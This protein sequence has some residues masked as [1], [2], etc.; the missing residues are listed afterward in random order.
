[1]L[2]ETPDIKDSILHEFAKNLECDYI[3]GIRN[4]PYALSEKLQCHNNVKKYKLGEP[5]LG[6]Y[7]LKFDNFY[8]AILHSVV[9]K[10]SQYLDITP[11]DD[12][13]DYIIFAQLSDEHLDNIYLPN[14]LFHSLAKYNYSDGEQNMYYIY[15]LI[16]PKN[17]QPFYIGKGMGNRAQTHLWNLS[18]SRNQYKDSKIQK[19]REQGLEPQVVYIAENIEN[20][21]LAYDLEEKVILYYGRKGYEVNGILTNVSLGVRP[22]NHKGKT[23]E[24]IYGIEGAK[25]Q[26]EMRSR[27]QKERGGY[28]PDRHSIETKQKISKKTAGKNNPRYGVIVK[29][30]ELAKKIGNAN[31]GKKHYQKS[32]IVCIE[33][34]NDGIID[35][36]WMNDLSE[37]CKLKNL[38]ISTFR[39]QLSDNWPHSKRGKNKNL[40]CRKLLANETNII[41][42]TFKGFSL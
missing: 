29:G 21:D 3:I 35:Y 41:E 15:A 39:K 23:Y 13:R 33:H 4:T 36:V 34:K 30:T 37:Y 40:L 9:Y 1:M 24:D 28:G 14:K 32:R 10:D 7:F 26:R 20:E 11:Y 16:N 5:R 31:K 38:S 2:W 42:D 25:I 22:P 19:I 27:L 18:N 6:Y 17:K 12:N 8:Q